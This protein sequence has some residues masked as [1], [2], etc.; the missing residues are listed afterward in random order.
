MSI[1]DLERQAGIEDR[2]AFWMPFAQYSDGFERGVAEL[3]RMISAKPQGR[4][5]VAHVCAPRPER[6]GESRDSVRTE[7]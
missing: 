2:T 6:S 4:T 5:A 1:G 3:R 7:Q